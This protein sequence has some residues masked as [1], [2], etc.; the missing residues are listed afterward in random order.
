[1][2][3]LVSIIIPVYN[4][5]NYIANCLDSILNQTYKNLEIICVDDGSKDGS[6]EIIRSYAENDSRIV[7]IYQ[8]NAGVSAAR[9]NALDNIHGDYV[10][11][12]D[13]DDW[14][15]RQAV[16]ILTESIEE[17][18]C[19]V[20][21]AD[22]YITDNFNAHMPKIEF[23]KCIP[24]NEHDLFVS[25]YDFASWSKIFKSSVIKKFRYPVGVTNGE[26]FYYF[27]QL[28]YSIRES[29][30]YRIDCKLY[31]YYS[32]EGSASK[33][34]FNKKTLTE[35]DSYDMAMEFIKDK[36][37]CYIKN[38]T[39][40]ALFKLLMRAR[41]NSIGTSFEKETKLIVKQKWKKWKSFLWKTNGVSL[42]DKLVY[43]SF[44]YSRHL[45]EFVRAVKDPTMKDF[46][47]NRGKTKN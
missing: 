32:R 7:Y 35:I 25:D 12:V 21:L 39:V 17:K 41:T 20:V 27:I 16:E 33:H 8:E 6:A 15:H 18:Q 38:Y 14:L 36:E 19:N 10:M 37:D 44:Y 2:S 34:S 5:E 23:K 4:L 29:I 1:M 42:K 40:V 47:N 24:V 46:Y 31:Y 11:F 13:G 26:D 43:T 22:F 45:Y 9:N 28:Y 30:G 3:A